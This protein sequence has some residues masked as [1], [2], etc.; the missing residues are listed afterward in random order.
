MRRRPADSMRWRAVNT[1]LGCAVVAMALLIGHAVPA[2]TQIMLIHR[3][4]AAGLQ[5]A[6][7]L[8]A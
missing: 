5:W 7:G 3:H 6:A 2:A 4:G 1:M 8:Y